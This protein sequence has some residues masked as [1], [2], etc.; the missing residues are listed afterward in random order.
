MNFFS[1]WVNE[2]GHG[3]RVWW[4]EVV[5]AP[6]RFSGSLQ[7]GHDLFLHCFPGENVKKQTKTEL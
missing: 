7:P 2:A 1:G 6:Q 4:M 3:W 5:E